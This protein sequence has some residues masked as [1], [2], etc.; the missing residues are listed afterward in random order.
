MKS[1]LW[2]FLLA[3]VVPTVAHASSSADFSNSGGTLAGSNSG[4]NLSGSTLV[5]VNG[6]S[7]LGLVTGNLGSVTFSTGALTGGSLQMGGT[8]AILCYYWKR[9][10]RYSQWNDVY[11]HLHR[12]A[13]LDADYAG[14]WDAQLHVDGRFERHVGAYRSDG[15]GRH[16]GVDGERG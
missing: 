6:L 4:L 16:G 11:W 5:A 9:L 14:E 2:L 3:L 8:F 1:M 10:R 15:A 13:D 7:G 12:A